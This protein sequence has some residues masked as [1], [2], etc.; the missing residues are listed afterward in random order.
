MLDLCPATEDEMILAFLRAEIDSHRF[1]YRA[2][3]G[4]L[5][6]PLIDNA[7]LGD[8]RANAMR[9]ALLRDTRGYGV[10]SAL[11]TGF[12]GNV[13][14]RRFRLDPEDVRALRYAN[15]ATWVDLSRGS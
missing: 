1:G 4:V 13:T 7:N 11:F 8:A 9:K 5:A 14:W 10:N 12:P 6:Q 15:Y 2:R 3:L